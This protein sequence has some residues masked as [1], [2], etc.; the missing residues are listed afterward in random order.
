MRLRR[1]FLCNMTDVYLTS[2]FTNDWNRKF[3][4]LI[5]KILT[6]NGFVCCLPQLLQ[7]GELPKI[8]FD[9]DIQ[10]IKNTKCI[11]AIAKNES[12]NW[13]AEIGYAYAC[14]IPIIALV[15]KEHKIP[16]IC[17]EMI[18]EK[19]EVADMDHYE[20][21]MSLLVEKIRKIIL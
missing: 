5:G 16:L 18:Q 13:G 14:N 12:P 2:T 3:N 7:E 11:V 1:L 17:N 6:T 9:R 4:P 19:I 10:G 21:Y 15:E 20:S 8:V